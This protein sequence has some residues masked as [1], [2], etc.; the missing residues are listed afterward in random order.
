VTITSVKCLKGTAPCCALLSLHREITDP[1][2]REFALNRPLVAKGFHNSYGLLNRV[3]GWP[4]PG[5]AYLGN[6]QWTHRRA[7]ELWY[8]HLE[9]NNL[10][11]LGH[12]NLW[13]LMLATI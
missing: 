6:P 2:E 11:H 8:H 7:K 12:L 10:R 5:D 4:D 13:H 9:K 1:Q 3:S